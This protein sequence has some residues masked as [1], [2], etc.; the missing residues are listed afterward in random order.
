MKKD[1]T[2]NDAISITFNR[3]NIFECNEFSFL[4]NEE[5][6]PAVIQRFAVYLQGI[7]CP[8]S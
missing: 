5:H 3:K 7:A 8:E 1:K 2:L 6:T 4:K